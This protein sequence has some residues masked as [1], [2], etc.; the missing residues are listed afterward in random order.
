MH[1]IFRVARPV[2]NPTRPGR[3]HQRR[4]L[5]PREQEQKTAREKSTPKVAQEAWKEVPFRARAALHARNR[6]GWGGTCV[7]D[8]EAHPHQTD[9]AARAPVVSVIGTHRARRETARVEVCARV[10]RQTCQNVP[11]GRAACHARILTLPSRECHSLV[12]EPRRGARRARGNLR[13]VGGVDRSLTIAR[14]SRCS[15]LAFRREHRYAMVRH[16]NVERAC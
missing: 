11:P 12:A 8:W 5:R 9:R 14:V 16:E 10:A 4:A 7:T 1:P 13:G 15:R 2:R 6:Q 3:R